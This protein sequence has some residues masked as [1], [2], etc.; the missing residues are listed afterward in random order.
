ML[1]R[2]WPQ[3]DIYFVNDS[4]TATGGTVDPS[5]PIHSRAKYIEDVTNARWQARQRALL[6]QQVTD[7]QQ[8]YV[9]RTIL[10]E[11]GNLEK[12]LFWKKP[13]ASINAVRAL[14][15]TFAGVEDFARV[16][17]HYMRRRHVL[18]LAN[19]RFNRCCL[20]CLTKIGKR[21]LASELHAVFDCPSHASARGRFALATNFSLNIEI[22]ST[23]QDLRHI[24]TY[25]R[26]NASRL[27]ELA[28]F[29]LNIRTTRR[30]EHRHLTSNGPNG[31][32]RVL[33]R[34]V[35]ECWRAAMSPDH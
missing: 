10:Q 33:R 28:K 13:T 7:R 4:L 12:P 3:C 32:I 9:L 19:D 21:V 22:E 35:W 17:S 29:L 16:N 11:L 8:D 20:A 25:T 34:L 1:R 31:R 6:A 26:H 14:V 23:A 2:I 5:S 15:R 18:G 30:R 27:G 24:V